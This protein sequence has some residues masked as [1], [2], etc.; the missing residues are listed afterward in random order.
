MQSA[1]HVSFPKWRYN[2]QT[3]PCSSLTQQHF[4]SKNNIPPTH[5][6]VEAEFLK[7]FEQSFFIAGHKGL[8]VRVDG[9]TH[10]CRL[11]LNL[12]LDTEIHTHTNRGRCQRFPHSHICFYANIMKIKKKRYSLQQDVVHVQREEFLPALFIE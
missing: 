12:Q 3:T 6:N 9:R 4:S 7:A 1:V 10:L 2:E 8:Q 5:L 11:L